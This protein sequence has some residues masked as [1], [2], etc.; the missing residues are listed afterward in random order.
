MRPKSLFQRSAR[1]RMSS[2]DMRVTTDSWLCQRPRA[3]SCHTSALMGRSSLSCRASR[4]FTR[5]TSF[6]SHR[7]TCPGSRQCPP[8][9]GRRDTRRR[10]GGRGDRVAGSTRTAERESQTTVERL[11][12][13]L[14]AG[15]RLRVEVVEGHELLATEAEGAGDVRGSR[16]VRDLVDPRAQ[17]APPAVVFEAPPIAKWMSWIESRRFSWSAS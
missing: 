8:S 3:S 12:G 7:V 15:R 13:G 14:V 11:V 2:G 5:W 10:S 9:Q 6:Q 1:A 4:R 16:V 17:R